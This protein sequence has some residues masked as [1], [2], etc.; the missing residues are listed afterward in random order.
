MNTLGYPKINIGQM[1]MKHRRKKDSIQLCINVR[2]WFVFSLFGGGLSC[3]LVAAYLFPATIK[4]SY[5][6]TSLD[7]R[8]LTSNTKIAVALSTTHRGLP[9]AQTLLLDLL[10]RNLSRSEFSRTTLPGNFTNKNRTLQ[11]YSTAKVFTTNVMNESITS[12]NFIQS[13]SMTTNMQT[14]QATAVPTS[15]INVMLTLQPPSDIVPMETAN[16]SVCAIL[17][18]GLGNQMFQF[19]TTY[20][21]AARKGMSVAIDKTDDLTK[22]FK[23][24]IEEKEN[25]RNVCK[26]FVGRAEKLNCGYDEEM[27]TFS[28]NNNYRVSTYLQSWIYF[29]NASN[30]LRK[31]FVFRDHILESKNKL[32]DSVLKKY[33]FTSRSNVTLIGVH[34]RRGDLVNHT[35]GYRVV[36]ESYLHKSVHY[37]QS[38]RLINVIFIICSNDMKWTKEFMP[39]GIRSEYME[40]NSPEVD[41]AILGS[42]DHMISSVGTFSWWSAWLTGGEVTFYQWPAKEG[43][44]LR[45][46]FSK[47]YVD[48]FHPGWIGLS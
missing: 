18:G 31:Q 37:F 4:V 16:Y 44:S 23:L 48:Y 34:I 15:N 8:L 45:K 35:F 20:R 24:D 9:S 25:Y 28:A 41:M 10:E 36:S 29:Y 12:S 17:T 19:A 1:K 40:G 6:K 27:A 5:K 30:S 38:K 14:I 42:C 7:L 3:L 21:L 39:K 22:V 46:Q 26:T 13:A 33:N 43:S 32:I 11:K 2:K 47:D